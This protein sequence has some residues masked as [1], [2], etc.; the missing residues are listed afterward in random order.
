MDAKDYVVN[1]VLRDPRRFIV[2]IYQR[3][4]Q[5]GRRRLEPLWE[6]IVAKADEVLEGNAR[7]MHYMGA[8]ILAP[9]G[10]ADTFATTPSIQVVDGQQRLTSFQLFLAA[11]R[12]QALALGLEDVG[13]SVREYL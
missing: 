2:P 9:T 1:E 8:L 4:Y 13:P 5:W 3:Q 12:E 7:F 6:D 11:L 10:D